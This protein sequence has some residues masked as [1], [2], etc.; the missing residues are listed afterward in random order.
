MHSKICGKRHALPIWSL[1]VVLL[2][3]VLPGQIRSASAGGGSRCS[4]T[5]ATGGEWP[6]LNLD[7]SNTRHQKAE[8][9]IGP[10]E[11]S[12]LEPAWQ[13]AAENVGADGAFQSTPILDSGCMYIASSTGWILALNADTGDLVWK[14]HF[15]KANLLALSAAY[16]NVYAFPYNDKKGARAVALDQFT[17][18]LVWET[19]RLVEP[20]PDDQSQ[21]EGQQPNNAPVIFD[22]MV[23][24]SP[25]YA[26]GSI[27]VPL[28]FIDAHTGK[29]IKRFHLISEKERKEGFGCCAM[30]ATPAVDL[31]AKI[32]YAATADSESFVKQ[33]DYNQAILKIDVDRKSPSFLEVLDSYKGVGERYID[34]QS[35]YNF[36]DSPTCTMF[37]GADDP[38][39]GTS[40]SSSNACL[41][42]DL[43]FGASPTLFTKDG[44]QMVADLQKA[45]VFHAV[46]T[47]DMSGAW[48]HTLSWPSVL[49]NAATSAWDGTNLYVTANGGNMFS[50]NDL[51]DI[52]WALSNGSDA[53]R[54]QPTTVANGVVYTL[55]NTGHLLARDVTT[56][57]PVLQRDVAGDVG[58]SSCFTLG[59]GVSIARNTVYVPCDGASMIVA[60]RPPAS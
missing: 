2:L 41:E 15:K 42:L 44:K 5:P 32:M 39:G 52:T 26:F 36:D 31:D 59:A 50:F 13:F 34:E 27:R 4:K 38:T 45:G 51:G 48:T 19:E 12:A 21:S 56:G 35:P 33:H 14:Y 29:I 3:S 55:T 10:D 60:Y 43:D 1:L 18:E 49:G 7:H 53:V 17:G 47:K 46:N 57:L 6:T 54:Y 30:W 58:E 40:T 8:K 20:I 11:A 22:G 28:Y 23:F 25:S 24:F 9:K 16:G 37:G